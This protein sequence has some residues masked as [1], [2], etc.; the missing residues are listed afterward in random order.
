MSYDR[1]RQYTHN[2]VIRAEG[3][4]FEA[5]TVPAVLSTG[6]LPREIAP[7]SEGARPW[8][9]SR[10]EVASAARHAPTSLRLEQGENGSGPRGLVAVLAAMVRAALEYER[11][12]G[13]GTS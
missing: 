9:P 10:V 12:S 5:G 6:D 7:A 4:D 2:A 1:L 3:V 13:R 11:R 8:S